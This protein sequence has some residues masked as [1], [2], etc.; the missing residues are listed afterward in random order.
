ML[1]A[2]VESFVYVSIVFQ[3]ENAAN[4]GT[5]VIVGPFRSSSRRDEFSRVFWRGKMSNPEFGSIRNDL[6]YVSHEYKY[7]YKYKLCSYS[8]LD[9][10]CLSVPLSL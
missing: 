4:D 7:K 8:I 9:Y 6:Q 3:Q 1:Y 10:F 2:I 5:T